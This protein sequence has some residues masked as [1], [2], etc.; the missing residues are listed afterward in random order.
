M[1][2]LF[3]MKITTCVMTMTTM[4]RGT[5][6]LF[7]DMLISRIHAWRD[8]WHSIH[9]ASCVHDTFNLNSRHTDTHIVP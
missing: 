4:M 5:E 1:F 2:S 9:T 6:T 8:A 3:Y 7:Q